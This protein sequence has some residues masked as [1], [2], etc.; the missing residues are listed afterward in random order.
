ML[1]VGS[2]APA[3]SGVDQHGNTVT[4]DSA[5]AGGRLV[6]YFYPKDFTRVCTAQACTF[7]DATPD[8]LTLSARVIGVSTDDRDTHGKF[9]DRYMVPYPLL[10]DRDGTIARAYQADRWLIGFAKRITYVIDRDRKILGAFHHE[11]SA[12][13]HLTDVKAT[14]RR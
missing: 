1:E 8:L 9:A 4:L 2:L 11:L 7:R 12:E 3:F 13:K 5:L 10:A 14:L 6:L